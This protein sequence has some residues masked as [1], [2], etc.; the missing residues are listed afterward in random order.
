MDD[1]AQTCVLTDRGEPYSS[2]AKPWMILSGDPS[3][4]MVTLALNP[5]SAQ[6]P[7]G[8]VPCCVRLHSTT[9]VDSWQL[10]SEISH[11][12]RHFVL[13]MAGQRSIMF[14]HLP[15]KQAL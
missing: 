13:H 14:K 6:R 15:H 12:N 4:S 11:P 2:G 10:S 9:A 3:S 7:T 1:T 8:S 5:T